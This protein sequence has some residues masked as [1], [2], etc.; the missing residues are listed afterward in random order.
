MTTNLPDGITYDDLPGFG[1]IDIIVMCTECRDTQ[2]AALDV[3]H[4]RGQRTF[5][6]VDACECCGANR[7]EFVRRAPSIFARGRARVI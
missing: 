3:R 4:T 6:M 1:E 7:W 2:E 5:D